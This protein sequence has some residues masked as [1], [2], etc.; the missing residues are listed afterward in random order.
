MESAFRGG[1]DDMTTP[2][3]LNATLRNNGNG[4]TSQPSERLGRRKRVARGDLADAEW[5]LVAPL[6]PAERGREGRPAGDNR[7]VVNGILWREC[8][9][10]EHA[11]PE[12]TS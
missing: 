6:L 1:D 3:S 8:G 7:V 5:E 10:A 12:A 4:V 11:R 9:C 2:A